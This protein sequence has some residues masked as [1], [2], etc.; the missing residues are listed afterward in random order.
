[1]VGAEVRWVP[2]EHGK[3]V[4]TYG[5][6][7]CGLELMREAWTNLQQVFTIR[8]QRI[9]E[10]EEKSPGP[11]VY[12]GSHR[13]P[14][15]LT[16]HQIDVLVVE[17]GHMRRAPNP[18]PKMTWLDMI[19]D[20]PDQSRPVVVLETWV[21]HAQLWTWG[22][23]SKG[24]TT[25]WRDEG[26]ESR[27]Q[28]IEST[29]VGGAIDQ[30]RLVV[31]RVNLQTPFRWVWAEP[32]SEAQVKRPM[33]NL[34][35]PPGLVPKTAYGQEGKPTE[36][37]VPNSN[38]D[39]MPYRKG[40]WVQTERG[41]RRLRDDELVRG[42]GGPKEWKGSLAEGIVQRTTSIFIWEHLASSLAEDGK[43]GPPQGKRGVRTHGRKNEDWEEW[44]ED[45]RAVPIAWKPPNLGPDG[46]WYRVRIRNLREATR[47][48]P[49]AQEEYEKGIRDLE[50][51]RTNYD[52][53]GPRPSTLQL[54]WWEFPPEHWQELRHG[55]PMNFLS[56]PPEKIHDNAD[57]TEEGLE[58][59]IE[60]TEELIS[61]G[62]LRPGNDLVKTTA[63]LF[64][65]DKPGQAGQYRV[66]ADM[67]RGG[68]N[69]HIGADPTVL[70]R[71]THIADQLY[72]GGYSSVIDASKYFYQFRTAPEDYPYLGVKHPLTGDL[73]YYHGLP[74]GSSQSPA[75][76]CRKGYGFLRKLR[77][78][79]TMFQGHPRANCW[80]TGFAGLGYNPDWGYGLAFL[81]SQGEPCVKVW[82][83]VDDF[84]IH[85]PTRDLVEQALYHFLDTA[86][87]VGMLC[88]P[89]KL[90]AP[91]QV[92][93]YCGFILDT[94]GQPEMRI[95]RSKR[96][97]ALAIS[98]LLLKEPTKKWSRLAL[99]VAAGVLESLVALWRE[100]Q[101]GWDTLT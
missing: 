68:Q 87:E 82:A 48:L 90:V 58:A 42:L 59:A 33:A 47:D 50:V 63:P 43:G 14:R 53:E 7:D 13:H 39:P 27:A 9:L 67:L 60:F 2:S 86:L 29:S 79:H 16:T 101:G 75:A 31:V 98:E 89:K 4:R 25:R 18:H 78:K 28:V 38:T 96:E 95:P 66:I 21:A 46:E 77:Q 94:R 10:L 61:L 97:R 71:V 44:E 99:S 32:E 72:R 100:H 5:T 41:T 65:V 30:S 51:H 17:R 37:R 8:H 52:D 45:P 36:G 1:M 40:A 49:N 83:F 70:P 62:V 84:L 57:M 6:I 34:L 56:P 73:Y 80:W 69:G 15:L 20:T 93:R 74:M 35:R 88:H 64:V 91:S 81:D 76:A 11:R 85:G 55:S 26:Y 19:A 24:H 22:P 92:V 54:L 23:M 3:L 12:L